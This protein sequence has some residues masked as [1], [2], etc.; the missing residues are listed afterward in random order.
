MA[1]YF[2]RPTHV[3]RV[4]LR[5]INVPYVQCP[6]A[7]RESARLVAYAGD[8]ARR[9]LSQAAWPLQRAA[10]ALVQRADQSAAGRAR[11]KRRCGHVPCAHREKQSGQRAIGQCSE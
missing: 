2:V 1:I 3:K 9:T 7:E 4:P 6:I 11:G 10:L 8:S 5:L